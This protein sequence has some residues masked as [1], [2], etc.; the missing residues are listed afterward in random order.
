MDTKAPSEDAGEGADVPALEHGAEQDA[1]APIISLEE[2]RQR[3]QQQ[4]QEAQQA[5][6][7]R[8]QRERHALQLRVLRDAL[9]EKRLDSAD[10]MDMIKL[11]I[12]TD[13][14]ELLPCRCR[15]RREHFYDWE[16]VYYTPK[17]ERQA[18]DEDLIGRLHEQLAE[19]FDIEVSRRLY[20][21]YAKRLPEPT[22][23]CCPLTAYEERDGMTPPCAYV[24]RNRSKME[25]ERDTGRIVFHPIPP[26]ENDPVVASEMHPC[27]VIGRELY[28]HI[29][30]PVWLRER[31]DND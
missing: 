10:L 14:E 6:E 4:Q 3:R 18:P 21:E 26:D 16:R 11:G 28:T 19:Q 13:D 27:V 23:V 12:V 31:G 30:L 22:E 5:N 29:M 9:H 15:S 8:R 2:A 20:E 24:L 25:W 7:R 17:E 1:G